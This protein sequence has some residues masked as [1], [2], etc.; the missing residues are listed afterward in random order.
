MAENS[1]RQAGRDDIARIMEFIKTYWLPTHILANDRMFFEYEHTCGDE[2]CFV[3]SEDPETLEVQ[4]ILGF[5]PYGVTLRDAMIVMWK[6]RPGENAFLGV[7][8]LQFLIGNIGARIVGSCGINK[9]VNG[10]YRYLGYHTGSLAQ[11]YRITD[12]KEYKIAVITEK[13]ILPVRPEDGYELVCFG[14]FGEIAQSFD[15]AAT[16]NAKPYKEPWYIEKRYFKHPVYTYKAYG[17]KNPAGNIQTLLFAREIEINGAKALRIVDLIGKSEPL[18]HVS[19][20]V[21]RLLDENGYEYADFY[22]Y[23]L[24]HDVMERAGFTLREG[25]TNIIPNYFEP[26]VQENIGIDYFTTDNEEFRIF[27][28]DGDQDR[29]S[30]L[31][32]SKPV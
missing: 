25:D 22:Q 4:A 19:A 15:F 2:V 3:L 8:V 9:R 7:K 13:N 31:G 24:P 27:K 32:R 12:R 20:G 26:F 21:Q 18:A 29:P 16:E 23:G 17:I 11:Y 30:L 6:A 1:I 14:S 5:I 28:A 10:I